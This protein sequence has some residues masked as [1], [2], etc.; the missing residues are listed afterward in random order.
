MNTEPATEGD[1]TTKM[2]GDAGEHYALSQF[3]FAGKPAAKMP[4]CWRSYD[5]AVE[6]SHGLVKVSVKTRRQTASWHAGS[7]FTFDERLKCDWLVFIFVP[8][9]GNLRSWVVPFSLARELGNK[10]GPKRK[11]PHNRDLSFAKLNREPLARYENNWN[12]NP[13]PSATLSTPQ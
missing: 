11:D 1:V 12:L 10:P 3:S 2:C 8:R 7:W 9:S 5:L 6:S 13:S 4:D